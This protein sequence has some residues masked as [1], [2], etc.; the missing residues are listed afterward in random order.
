MATKPLTSPTRAPLGALL[1]ALLL[2]SAPIIA[3]FLG[4]AQ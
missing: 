1:T 4:A 3:L 2:G